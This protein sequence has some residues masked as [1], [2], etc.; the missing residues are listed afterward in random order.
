MQV[1]NRLPA[2]DVSIYDDAISIVRKTSLMSQLRDGREHVAES[3]RVAWV[4]YRE[5]I[6]MLSRN[7]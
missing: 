4:G 2:V 3:R 5:R 7:N 6:D 1:K